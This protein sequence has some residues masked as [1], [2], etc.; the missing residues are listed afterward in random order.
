MFEQY[1][2]ISVLREVLSWS[3]TTLRKR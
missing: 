1:F 3:W 2:Y